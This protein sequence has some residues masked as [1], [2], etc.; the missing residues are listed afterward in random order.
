MHESLSNRGK[1]AVSTKLRPD[2]EIFFEALQ[3]AWHAEENIKGSFPLNMAENK[4]CW[5]ML[6]N[7]IQ[8][9]IRLR[10]IPNWVANYTGIGGAD[11]FLEVIAQFLSTYLAKTQIESIHLA[12][13][14]GATAVLELASM[15]LCDPGDVAVIPAPSYPVY[16]QDIGNKA[17]VKRYDLNI[18]YDLPRLRADAMLTIEQLEKAKREITEKG[19]EFRILLITRPDNPTGFVYSSQE[20]KTIANWCILNNVH[21]VIN[22]LYGLSII[23]KTH[24]DIA[25][26]YRSGERFES[27][28]PL[29]KNLQSPFVH[30]VYGLSKDFGISGFRV[31]FIYSQNEAFLTA[32]RNLNAPHMISNLTQW[33]ISECLTDHQFVSSFIELN[34]KE[35]TNSYSVVIRMLKK[36]N[37]PYIPSYGGLFVWI[38]LSEFMQEN[39]YVEEHNLWLSLYREKGILLT[40]GQGFGHEKF[41]QFRL[42][43]TFLPRPTLEM[44]MD[45]LSQYVYDHRSE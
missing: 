25:E 13:S 38:D 42:I 34:Q 1:D 18:F 36:L 17:G 11:E 31:G 3:N 2:I 24:K 8:D 41:G 21:L 44:A 15:V 28:F 40:P 5:P 22:E 33:I 4:L 16:T 29:V 35:I 26:D 9:I 19:D 37:I 7:K 14:A 20:L 10:E 27:A 12:A 23:D 30:I 45:K 39:S 6:R 32:Y 43:F